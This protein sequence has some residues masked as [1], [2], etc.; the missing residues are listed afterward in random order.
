MKIKRAQTDADELKRQD[1]SRVDI[2]FYGLAWP[3]QFHPDPDPQIGMSVSVLLPSLYGLFT[4]LLDSSNVTLGS[5]QGVYMTSLYVEFYGVATPIGSQTTRS[6]ISQTKRWALWVDACVL[7]DP[8]GVVRS[9]AHR[10]VGG[11]KHTFWFAD[12]T[13][14]NPLRVDVGP[15]FVGLVLK[16]DARLRSP[17]SLVARVSGECQVGG[18]DKPVVS[19]PS[20]GRVGATIIGA[21]DGKQPRGSTRVTQSP[22]TGLPPIQGAPSL[23]TTYCPKCEA[24]TWS[25]CDCANNLL[26]PLGL[27]SALS[28][29]A[30]SYDSL[31]PTKSSLFVLTCTAGEQRSPF[32]L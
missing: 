29:S 11:E 23:L 2:D 12:F 16:T 32:L 18:H 31:V 15:L 28:T 10:P 5:V 22:H 6:D 26:D 13:E 24:L 20:L 14:A 8:S 30:L 4:A 17:G 1:A 27:H 21:T 25:R 19:L 9:V 7:I 3:V